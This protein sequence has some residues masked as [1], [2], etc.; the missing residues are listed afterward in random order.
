MTEKMIIV[1][2]PGCPRCEQLVR[3]AGRAA[4]ELGIKY[5][6][7]KLSDF[8]EFQKY[9]LMMTPGLVVNEK[10]VCSGRIPSPAEVTT[11]LI[12]ELET[13]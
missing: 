8:R 5:H 11:W 9:G 6:L 13:G 3:V 2:G 4:E 10:L 1:L 7:E 12:N